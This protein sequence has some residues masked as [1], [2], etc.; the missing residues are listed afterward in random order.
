MKRL[1]T[2]ISVLILLL[3]CQPPDANNRTGDQPIIPST[4]QE[5]LNVLNDAAQEF[6]EMAKPNTVR[7]WVANLKVK[8]QPGRDMK[9]VAVMAEGEEARYLYQR[10]MRKETYKLRDQSYHDTWYLIR[11]KDS[12]LGWVHGGGIL[13]VRQDLT[14]IFKPAQPRPAANQRTR[15]FTDASDGQPI[16]SPEEQREREKLD[17]LV[18]PGERIGPIRVNTSE[19]ELIRLYGP[20]VKRGELT[21]FNKKTAVTFLFKGMDEE[22][23]I[24]WK[25]PQ[26][27]TQIKAVHILGKEGKW[28]THDGLQAGLS[29]LDLTKINKSPV[30]FFGLN[31]E[32]GGTVDSYQTGILTKQKKFFYIVLRPRRPQQVKAF[33]GGFSGNKLFSS[34]TEGV[35]K[36]DL[37]IDSFVVYLD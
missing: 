24:Q 5:A 19:D 15:S 30:N 16:M 31:W 17:F 33:I 9:Q 6:Q 1:F 4:P 18:I 3:G 8:E 7:S 34:K 36:L 35:D 22:L 37:I 20:S 21:I 23:A 11:T 12:V 25:D 10:T 29:L 27:R 28:H 32:Y 13:F 26:E 14:G 2:H